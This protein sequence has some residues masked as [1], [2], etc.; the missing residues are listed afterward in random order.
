MQPAARIGFRMSVS[1]A[2][3]C[4]LASIQDCIQHKLASASLVKSAA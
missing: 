1:V 4:A 2:F 3:I